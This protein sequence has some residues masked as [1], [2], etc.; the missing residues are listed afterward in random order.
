MY[1][2]SVYFSSIL[3]HFEIFTKRNEN[4]AALKQEEATIIC[5]MQQ[6]PKIFDPKKLKI[7]IDCPATQNIAAEM[8]YDTKN[9]QSMSDLPAK[10]IQKEQFQLACIFVL[11][12]C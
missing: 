11:F 8:T 5:Q 1:P 9:E 6:N 4:I 12:L 2:S 7:K 3:Y 10:S